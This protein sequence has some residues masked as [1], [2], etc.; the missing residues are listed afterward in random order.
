[1]NLTSVPGYNTGVDPYQAINA[2]ANS[3]AQASQRAQLQM[4]ILMALAY[5]GASGNSGAGALTASN[6]SFGGGGSGPSG[7]SS[8]LGAGASSSTGSGG[9]GGSGSGQAAVDMAR[10]FAGKDS[11]SIKGKMPHFT[12]AG[13][14]N[15][16]C[17]DFVSSA[18][19]SQ[20]LI[21]GHHINVKAMEQEL[22]KQGYVQV[23]ASQAKPGDVWM[24][25]SRSHTELVATKGA[26][27]LIGS[28]NNGDSRQEITEHAN[29]PS[30]GII[31]QK[32]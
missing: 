15:N 16:N 25:H 19:E 4:A 9:S 30:S 10:K 1:M 22:K 14:V 7:I 27:K 3:Q 20:G 28:N 29:Q 6:P 11:S 24:S 17:A 18:L 5:T 12:A 13:G 26:T 8:F 2:I 23:P 21:K 31:Y 32:R